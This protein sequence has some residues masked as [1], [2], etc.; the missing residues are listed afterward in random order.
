MRRTITVIT[1]AMLSIAIGVLAISR[2]DAPFLR[3]VLDGPVYGENN[4]LKRPENTESWVFLGTTMGMTY[5]DDEPAPGDP[6]LFSTVLMEPSA[7]QAFLDTGRFADG[8]VFAKIVRDTITSD[9][10]FSMGRE[11]GMEVHVK[12]ETRFPKHGF[13]FYFFPADGDD[14]ASAL[15]NDNGCISCHQER[16]EFDDVFTQFYPTLRDKVRS[17]SEEP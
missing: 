15:P 5:T 1:L 10:G 8:T 14:F 16:A 3:P 9:G 17:N 7:Y 11:L 13:N 4:A 6:G 12:D 2:A